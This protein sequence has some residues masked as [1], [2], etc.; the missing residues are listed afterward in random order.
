MHFL[1]LYIWLLSVIPYN[2]IVIHNFFFTSLAQTIQDQL[3]D[4]RMKL[5]MEEMLFG[6]MKKN[7]RHDG[8][9]FISVDND[10]E[11]ESGSDGEGYP[12]LWV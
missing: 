7:L 10:I 11:L 2:G 8:D 6:G 1:P 5:C 9:A 4:F 12:K 3:R